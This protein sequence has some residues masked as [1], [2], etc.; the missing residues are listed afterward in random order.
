[1]I[2]CFLY[3]LLVHINRALY[4]V[5]QGVG[6]AD[7]ELITVAIPSKQAFALLEK[8]FRGAENLKKVRLRA[9]RGELETFK[10]K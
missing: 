8:T 4:T 2:K 6:E 9:L 5:Y 7:F 3:I 1:M 10:M